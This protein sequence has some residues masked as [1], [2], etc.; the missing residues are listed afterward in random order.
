M[1]AAST[2]ALSRSLPVTRRLPVTRM[3]GLAAAR[4]LRLELRHNAMLWMIPLAVGLFWYQAFRQSM[5]APP[6]WNLRAMT[7]QN[8]ALLDFAMP[9]AGAAAWMGSR[10]GRRD[11]T[12]ML[13]GTARSR[14]ARQLATW[15]ATT[16]WAVIAYLGCVAVLY[17][18]TARQ[19][20]WGGPLWWPA[21]VGAVGI[22]A[23]TAIAFAARAFFPNR[24]TTPLVTFVAFFGLGFGA[25]AAHG[26][27]SYWQI[28][29]QISGAVDVGPDPGVATFYHYLPDLS[30]AQV[31]FLAGLAAAA[32]VSW[33][34]R[35]VPAAGRCAGSPRPSPR[36]ACWPRAPPSAWPEPPAWTR[37]A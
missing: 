16:C 12:S 18:I 20:T 19:A 10:E 26:G 21:A 4:L 15:A 34:C 35:A 25:E 11:T 37:T 27:T 5:A 7:M 1:T 3:P 29:P 31:M 2:P 23:I 36:P 28:M 13:T 32:F 6:M 33:A 14:W 24:F 30:L 9:V 17:G 8:D 22:P